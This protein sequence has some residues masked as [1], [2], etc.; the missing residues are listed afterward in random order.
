MRRAYSTPKRNL[1]LEAL[2]DEKV[3]VLSVAYRYVQASVQGE[4]KARIIAC[5]RCRDAAAAPDAVQ[6]WGLCGWSRGQDGRHRTD[7]Q[8]RH[9]D[10]LAHLVL[11]AGGLNEARRPNLTTSCTCEIASRNSSGEGAAAA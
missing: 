4:L 2:I 5:L 6:V 9:Q 11:P 10:E 1:A 7:G 8:S 3:E